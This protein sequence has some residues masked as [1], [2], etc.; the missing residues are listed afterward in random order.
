MKCRKRRRSSKKELY[1]VASPNL[2][3]SL[4]QWSLAHPYGKTIRKPLQLH[5]WMQQLL[6][7]VVPTKGA[8][9][10]AQAS[11]WKFFKIN[12]GTRKIDDPA[13]LDAPSSIIDRLNTVAYECMT[14]AL[15]EI[16]N[17]KGCTR[18][19]REEGA[20]WDLPCGKASEICSLLFQPNGAERQALHTDGHKR[21]TM[22]ATPD[23]ILYAY[24]LNILVPLI[25]D[26]P[27]V[28]RS[29]QRKLHKGPTC[30][31]DM[32]RI[33]NGGLWHG[34]DAN[35]TGAGVWKLFLGL[36]PGDHPTAGDFPV[37]EAH[38]GKNLAEERQ[39]VVLVADDRY[40]T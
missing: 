16:A 31:P 19:C 14:A 25:G 29:P 15:L 13:W 3:V 12:L 10:H 17:Y 30:G 33:F 28:F 1:P 24:F 35:N 23:K 34:G 37:F 18:V 4:K 38:A 21:Y 8:H 2:Y 11:K 39:R 6:D 27:T 20:I 36:V 22:P 9:I 7:S 32:I 5:I 40:N 26:V